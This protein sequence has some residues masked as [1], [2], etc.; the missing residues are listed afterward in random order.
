MRETEKIGKMENCKT[1]L[2]T[3]AY[4]PSVMEKLMLMV[5]YANNGKMEW[6][7]LKWAVFILLKAHEE[8][9]LSRG[10]NGSPEQR[11]AGWC[12]EVGLPPLILQSLMHM[13]I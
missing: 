8:E 6:E 13:C 10:G 12:Q 7:K 4:E 9:Q 2:Q 5:L 1:D 3:L 11:A